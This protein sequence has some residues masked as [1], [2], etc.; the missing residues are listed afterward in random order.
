VGGNTFRT[1]LGVRLRGLVEERK[2]SFREIAAETDVDY[3]QVRR[4]I[5]GMALPSKALLRQICLFFHA[6]FQQFEKI[7]ADDQIRKKHGAIRV[8]HLSDDQQLAK[9]ERAWPTLTD[10]QKEHLMMTVD[11]FIQAKTTSP[12]LEPRPTPPRVT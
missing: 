11:V 2:C 3:E 4:V 7:R 6:D 1:E 8:R 10:S 12:K 9:L 5:Q